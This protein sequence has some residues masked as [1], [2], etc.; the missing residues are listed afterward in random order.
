MGS[1]NNSRD[2]SLKSP[3]KGQRRLIPIKTEDRSLN[4]NSLKQS[5]PRN[6]S[7]KNSPTIS[8]RLRSSS[9][10]KRTVTKPVLELAEVQKDADLKAQSRASK[11]ATDRTSEEMIAK[12]KND[13]NI[14]KIKFRELKEGESPRDR[15]L[16][17][18][19]DPMD[20]ERQ[21]TIKPDG[22]DQF[23]SIEQSEDKAGFD[24]SRELSHNMSHGDSR[25]SIDYKDDGKELNES[26]YLKGLINAND[27][28]LE[29]IEDEKK[30]KEIKEYRQVKRAQ[31]EEELK[32]DGRLRL[33][34]IIDR[35]YE[36]FVL[37]EA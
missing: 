5:S 1:L 13:L 37:L 31:A 12:L 7:K 33:L 3:P 20:F 29:A 34:E 14:P 16:L 11:E 10:K 18:E 6:S 17:D 8:P 19:L 27:D 22:G 36:E 28:D 25:P 23:S 9:K 2:I 4:L 32:V 24:Y 15:D 21:S 30:R 35:S 26:D